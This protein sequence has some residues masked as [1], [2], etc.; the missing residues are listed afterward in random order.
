MSKSKKEVIVF[1]L[2]LFFFIFLAVPQVNSYPR[3]F[4]RN[5]EIT[6]MAPTQTA[7]ISITVGNNAPVIG[8]VTLDMAD[9]VSIVESGNRTLLFSFL[10]TDIEGAGNIDNTSG[11]ANI[12]RGGET[13]RHN[14]TR[15]YATDGGCKAIN[16]YG[17]LSIN[18]SCS[19]PIVFYDGAGVWNIS[20]SAKD[21][22]NNYAFNTTATFTLQE[23]TNIAI[24]VNTFAFS[25]VT[26]DQRNV[27]STTL[28]LVNNTGNDD[29]SGRDF[30]GEYINFTA[31]TLIGEST[32]TT[33]IP[34]GNFS[35]G[36]TDGLGTQPAYCDLS[37]TQ[38]VT[39]LINYS[40]ALSFYNNFSAG[41]NG[42]FMLAQASGAQ[43][44]LQLCF[45]DVP[46]DLTS[47][48]Y[49]TLRSGSWSIIIW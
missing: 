20:V 13:T 22:N 49:S 46:D 34:T 3:L 11:V 28:I 25:A 12:S 15:I 8:N 9:S 23:S 43:E 7:S 48:N 37:R 41:I 38:N 6:G 44:I 45:L 24:D 39:R 27:T 16:S 14:D 1:L 26:P 10:V 2:I 47:Q 33:A 42:S 17:T 18:F 29:I 31:I 36:T 35:V 30:S 21:N 19:I 5:N 40:A 32:T 4:N